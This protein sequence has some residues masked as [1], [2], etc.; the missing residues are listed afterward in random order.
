MIK[1][2]KPT[3]EWPRRSADL[4][5]PKLSFSDRALRAVLRREVRGPTR[6]DDLMAAALV[7]LLGTV[8]LVIGWALFLG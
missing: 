6:F 1:R 3:L 4:L 7:V 5:D 8:G 2:P